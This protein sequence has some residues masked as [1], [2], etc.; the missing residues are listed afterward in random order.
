M[1]VRKLMLVAALA[2]M[3][4]PMGIGAQGQYQADFPVVRHQ[5]LRNDVRQAAYTL[6]LAAAHVREEVGRTR[7]GD[8]GNRLLAAESRLDRLVAQMRTGGGVNVAT[9]DDAFSATDRLLAEHH[10]RLAT[11][12]WTNLRASSVSQVGHDLER[13]TFHY[14]RSA[15]WESRTLDASTQQVLSDAE[16]V[17][18]QLKGQAA[19]PPK[20]TGTVIAALSRVI[21]PPQVVAERTGQ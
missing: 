14:T 10:V 6:M 11:W 2:V 21:I 9:L 5:F 8:V 4:A 17:A 19:D 12:A 1:R 20:E 15:R 7:D 16:R 13:A 18:G 3:A